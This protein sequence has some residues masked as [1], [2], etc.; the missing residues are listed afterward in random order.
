MR[1][2]LV[3]VSTGMVYIKIKSEGIRC[4]EIKFMRCCALIM[5]KKTFQSKSYVPALAEIA[6]FLLKYLI[7]FK[8]KLHFF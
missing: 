5:K 7:L 2:E 8:N 1:S 3:Y 6:T 4:R